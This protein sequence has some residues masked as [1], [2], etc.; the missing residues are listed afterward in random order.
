MELTVLD[1]VRKRFMDA[2]NSMVV[3]F[4]KNNFKKKRDKNIISSSPLDYSDEL[5]RKKDVLGHKGSAY[6]GKGSINTDAAIFNRP[7]KEGPH[8]RQH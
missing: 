7:R 8:G 3:F 6:K 5:V 1:N 2:L 4:K